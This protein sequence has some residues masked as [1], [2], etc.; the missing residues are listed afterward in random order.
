MGNNSIL[1]PAKGPSSAIRPS[2][3]SPVDKDQEE[4]ANTIE[5]SFAELWKEVARFARDSSTGLYYR[6]NFGDVVGRATIL[7]N[8]TNFAGEYEPFSLCMA[9]IDN[10]KLTR[11][12]DDSSVEEGAILREVAGIIEACL[13]P[14]DMACYYQEGVFAMLLFGTDAE[15]AMVPMK[16]IKQKI[17]DG[18]LENDLAGAGIALSIGVTTFPDFVDDKEQGPAFDILLKQAEKALKDSQATDGNRITIYS[19]DSPNWKNRIKQLSKEK[20]LRK[21]AKIYSDAL[22]LVVAL[23]PDTGMLIIDEHGVVTFSELEN[24]LGYS[25]EEIIG[26]HFSFLRDE[27]EQGDINNIIDKAKRLGSTGGELT[28]KSKKGEERVVVFN[29]ISKNE[30]GESVTTVKLRDI[31]EYKRLTLRDRLT[32]ALNRRFF[33]DQ[34]P[35]EISTAKRH[36]RVLSLL[37]LDIDH[38]KKVNDTWGHSAGDYVLQEFVKIIEECIRPDDVL[39]RYGGEEFAVILPRTSTRRAHLVA[40]RIRTAIEKSTFLETY[41]EKHFPEEN[42]AHR[43][44][45][46]S[47]GVSTFPN[48]LDDEEKAE[49]ALVEKA[50]QAMYIS[51]RYRRNC[52]TE[53]DLLNRQ[54]RQAI[55]KILI[56]DDDNKFVESCKGYLAGHTIITAGSGREAL[57]LIDRNEHEREPFDLIL[58]DYRM[59]SEEEG[60][61]AMGGDEFALR[62][63][64]Q[65]IEK[66]QQKAIMIMV[67]GHPLGYERGKLLRDIGVLDGLQQKDEFK[68]NDF[69]EFIKVWERRR[70]QT[71]DEKQFKQAIE[72][73]AIK[74]L[75]EES[76]IELAANLY[77]DLANKLT[78][79]INTPRLLQVAL[80]EDTLRLPEMQLILSNTNKLEKDYEK[81]KAMIRAVKG[82]VTVNLMRKI[83]TS[84]HDFLNVLQRISNNY[85]VVSNKLPDEKFEKKLGY[86]IEALQEGKQLID[87]FT[88]KAEK[89]VTTENS[90]S[91]QGK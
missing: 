75:E 23:E 49:Q 24:I 90:K 12:S 68:D 14:S 66:G 11:G 52:V 31:T 91:T 64:N 27:E 61:P 26:K 8:R 40:E 10:F 62:F 42:K 30:N 3:S 86:T 55:G 73:Q 33:D 16:K 76:F 60:K 81:S 79:I 20:E 7:S 82:G 87:N 45:T 78:I 9:A 2:S 88:I 44:I 46:V 54:P 89:F 65:E 53:F 5:D 57:E 37:F 4:S 25:E 28:V 29:A 36:S 51:K 18:S 70:L 6:S 13:R 39:C 50:D 38:F 17:E 21:R 77:H 19:E 69:T 56:I 59:D 48:C 58:V 34:L 32:E 72:L 22:H 80:F 43:N 67:T 41:L 63:R 1:H 74:E 35:T 83:I 15:N 47:I 84:W 71:V 85:V